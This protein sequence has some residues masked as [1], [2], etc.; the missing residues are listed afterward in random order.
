MK[1]TVT[2]DP[3]D[4]RTR[5]NEVSTW[6]EIPGLSPGGREITVRIDVSQAWK[7]AGLRDL[8]RTIAERH[9]DA[10][11]KVLKC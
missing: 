4:F 8:L 5:G 10:W 7:V 2:V 3:C 1:K 11:D 6:V 9:R